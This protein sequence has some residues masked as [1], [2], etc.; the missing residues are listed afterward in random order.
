MRFIQLSIYF[1]LA[2]AVCA[3]YAVGERISGEHAE[4]QFSTIRKWMKN[5]LVVS[6]DTQ[7]PE[8]DTFVCI[9]LRNQGKLLGHG[10]GNDLA[11]AA[12]I[13]FDGLR[14]HP[15]FASD[16]PSSSRSTI[17]DGISIEVEQG[18]TPIPS[19]YKQID[20]FNSSF[21]TG[22]DGIGVRKGEQWDVRLQ[23]ELRL[24]PH[25][26]VTNIVESLCINLGMHPT[27]VLS[28]ELPVNEDV[29]LYAIPL[30]TYVQASAHATIAS[31]MR[32]DELVQEV[33]VNVPNLILFGDSLASHLI[34]S[35][36]ENGQMIGG[37]QPETNTLTTMFATHFVQALSAMA[38]QEYGVTCADSTAIETSLSILTSIATDVAHSGKIDEESAALVVILLSN[39]TIN[40][41]DEIQSLFLTCRGTILHASETLLNEKANSVRPFSLSLVASATIEL[42]LQSND[43]ALLDRG[44]DLLQKCF[45]DVSLESRMSI[46][47]WVIEPATK[48]AVKEEYLNSLEE[49]LQ[50]AIASQVPA[51]G[52]ADLVGGFS[53][54]TQRDNTVDARG[55][56]MIP[57][58]ATMSRASQTHK[59]ESFQSLV[60]AIR[61]AK[62]LTT[63]KARAIR[64]DN[65]SMAEGGVRTS[66]WNAAMPTEA[67]A[68]A[69][70]G[71]TS[72]I[73][74]VRDMESS[75]Q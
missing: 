34:K 23:A 8:K 48:D 18:G 37:F 5:G 73:K 67:T 75:I 26:S 46:L 29:T 39:A 1:A 27:V 16:F 7:T 63:Q 4:E 53:L 56:R 70:L 11:A 69:L 40:Q 3:G 41:H 52:E 55:L 54:R 49:L 13:A 21:K 30:T 74:T 72:A 32:G 2:I 66:C 25:R 59:T 47:P 10:T 22:A 19:P 17:I 58:L 15:V 61:F 71:I 31:L 50:I 45:T 36:S 33:R 64:F 14:N 38:L 44:K 62:Q 57:L 65:A 20:R 28:H 42:A 6:A 51:I 35:T 12:T 9:V 68:M 24:S 60:S 43:V